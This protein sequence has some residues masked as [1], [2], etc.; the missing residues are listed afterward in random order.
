MNSWQILT[1]SEIHQVTAGWNATDLEFGSEGL[2]HRFFE[3]QAER[4]PDAPALRFQDQVLSYAELEDRTRKVASLLRTQGVGPDTLVGVYMERSVE[5][6]VAL[7]GILR[8]GGAYLPLEPAYPPKRLTRMV[9]DAKPHAVLTQGSLRTTIDSVLD[10]AHGG[11]GIFD[12]EQV[13]AT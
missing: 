6:V 11:A 3:T 8:S 2:A 4:T 5:M 12:S 7:M 10:G 1:D 9:E 13:G